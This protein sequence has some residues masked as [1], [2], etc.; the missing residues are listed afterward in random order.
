MSQFGNKSKLTLLLS[1]LVALTTGCSSLAKVKV[2]TVGKVNV[3]R[4]ES[5][6]YPLAGIKGVALENVSGKILVKSGDVS[7]IKI[8]VLRRGYGKDFAEASESLNV[9]KP[10]FM[11]EDRYLKIKQP[12]DETISFSFAQGFYVKINH[13]ADFEVTLPKKPLEELAIAQGKGEIAID[14]TQATV[15][16]ALGEG[17][18]RARNIQGVLDIAVGHGTALVDG[19][20]GPTNVVVKFGKKTVTD[21]TE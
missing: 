11:I 14:G 20:K 16:V 12:K 13:E 3:P 17:E 15:S 7:E 4:Q 9:S 10:S 19:G 21:R 5:Y 6:Q 18:V 2:V 8:N 1:L